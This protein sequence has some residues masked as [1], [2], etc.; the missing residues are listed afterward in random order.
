MTAERHHR[1]EKSYPP[2]VRWDAPLERTTLGD[3]IDGARAF[4][5]R[6]ALE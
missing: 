4:G 2:G 6:I 1:W 3:L 5:P